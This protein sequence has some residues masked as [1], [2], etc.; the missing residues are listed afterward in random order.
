MNG[1]F[2]FVVGSKREFRL[3][4][5]VGI[6]QGANYSYMADPQLCICQSYLETTEPSKQKK[7]EL[8]PVDTLKTENKQR[9]SVSFFFGA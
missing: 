7:G 8:F 1:L 2:V 3:N 4:C 5:I 9:F 6:Y